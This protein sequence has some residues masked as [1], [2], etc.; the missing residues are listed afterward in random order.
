MALTILLYCNETVEGGSNM[1]NIKQRIVSVAIV[2]V[3][4]LGA[5][6]ILLSLT[7]VKGALK[8]EIVDSLRGTAAATL[9]AYDQNSGS[10]MESSNGDI[11]KG[12]YNIS[13]SETLVDSIKE[14]S[15][16]D[17]T[18]FY[19]DRRV[20]TTVVD[21]NGYRVLG[22]PAGDVV[23]QKVLKDGE[24]YF[25]ESVLLNGVLNYGYYVPVFEKATDSPVG[26]IFVGTAK[27]EK[28]A[29]MNHMLTLIIV[30]VVVVMLI[31]AVLAI[32]VAF[33]VTKG[34]VVGIE[35]MDQVSKGDL[36]IQVDEKMLKRKDEIGKMSQAIR[37]LQEALH[38]MIYTIGAD[39]RE[40]LKA[41]DNLND[42][43]NV[44]GDTLAQMETD[45]DRVVEMAEESAKCARDAALSMEHM[46]NMI[47]ETS[48][49]VYSLNDNASGMKTMSEKTSETIKSLKSVND[50]VRNAVSEIKEQ[51]YQTNE[52][53][54]K[55]KEVTDFISSIAEET[56]LLALNASIE[57]ARAGEAGRG[58]S[59]VA[60]QIQKLAEQTNESSASIAVIVGALIE[61]S[62]KSVAQM[63]HVSDI[64]KQQSDNMDETEQSVREVTDGVSDSIK[65]IH[66]IRQS[67]EELEKAREELSRIVAQLE[68]LSGQNAQGTGETR[69]SVK[70]VLDTFHHVNDAARRLKELSDELNGSV[71]HF[72]M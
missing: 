55:I 13:K 69:M 39:A 48:K 64:V 56:N 45:M 4:V 37:R 31:V 66:A 20:M 29:A 54:Q 18:F 12:N 41:S 63:N 57:A 19:G 62:A 50:E 71:E 24:G 32:L 27:A 7:V 36:T 25:S 21:E 6:T 30:A 49:E 44:T 42:T 17:V 67:T 11:W 58:F 33:S 8:D 1:G 47:G 68:Q 9:A 35:A 40:L 16:M 43:A 15:G 3:L 70:D 14:N 26:M 72:R 38:S 60:T 52:S 34:L 51:T 65:S 59:V 46:G 22:S 23:T 28:D 2:P 10:Y 53:V 5:I 61:E